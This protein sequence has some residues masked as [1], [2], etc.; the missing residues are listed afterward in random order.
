METTINKWTDP[1]GNKY[2]FKDEVARAQNKEI[3]KDVDVER[4]R[5]DNFVTSQTFEGK[6]TQSNLVFHAYSGA[7]TGDPDPD[8]SYN[9]EGTSN[10]HEMPAYKSFTD[11]TLKFAKKQSNEKVKITKR[12]LYLFELR[13][14]LSGSGRLDIEARINNASQRYNAQKIVAQSA[15]EFRLLTY[16]LYL[17]G[18]DIVSFYGAIQA[19]SV[20]APVADVNCYVLDWEGKAEIPDCSKEL[21]DVRVGADGVTYSNAGT[22]VRKQFENASNKIDE[23]SK[24]IDAMQDIITKLVT[25]PQLVAGKN[26]G[27]QIK[28]DSKSEEG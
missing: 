25:A 8:D 23:L 3:M 22:A 11:G 9:Y 7:T 26:G 10:D 12:G 17:H 19:G 14:R 20:K 18:N 5:I 4:K 28:Y 21:S 24:K 16:V 13:I 1:D 2:H 6:Y 27:L 15:E